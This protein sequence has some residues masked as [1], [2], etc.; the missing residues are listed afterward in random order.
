MW[1]EWEHLNVCSKYQS[2]MANAH[3]HQILLENANKDQNSQRQII[4]AVPG[5]I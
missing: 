5:T 1:T 2:R 4:K 3:M